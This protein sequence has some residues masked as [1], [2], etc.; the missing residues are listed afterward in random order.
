MFFATKMNT[1]VNAVI[2][3]SCLIILFMGG[4]DT[5]NEPPPPPPPPPANIDSTFTNPLLK[6][7]ADPWVVKRDSFYYY[8]NT[9][10]NRI[11]IRRTKYMSELGE[12]IPVV[13]WRTPKGTDHS[14]GIW[15]PEMHYIKGKWYMYFTA[16]G[17]SDSNRRM[18]VLV[19]NS[20]NPM[21]PGSWFYKGRLAA[22]PDVWAI[23]GT[24]LKYQNKMY[25]I[26]SGWRSSD[27]S[28]SGHQQLY[29]AKMKNPWTLEGKRVMI[30][31]PTY[32]WEK[33]GDVN[34]APEILKNKN[35]RVFLIYSASGCWTD[36]Y[37][38]G[39][40]T[41]K[42]GGNP[43]NP[44][45]WVKNPEPVLSTDAASQAYG[46]GHCSFFKSPDGTETWIIYHANPQP[47]QG[48]D[49]HRS[50]RMQKVRWKTDGTPYF[51]K[52]VPIHKPIT[53]PSGGY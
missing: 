36:H 43:M 7:G 25:L 5:T 27:P 29:I 17:G 44:D 50:P 46:T 31:E 22:N 35:G 48:C 37:T 3:I 47:H 18:H 23:D 15:A 30:S 41:L 33:R 10:G 49:G 4:C 8:M 11:A 42:E 53:K 38:L 9:L 14:K 26:W 20:Q 1:R 19:S 6:H 12:S 2:L 51:G 24:V 28:N 16:T 13:I 40:L 32:S 45:D 52:P 34:E 21:L 39:M